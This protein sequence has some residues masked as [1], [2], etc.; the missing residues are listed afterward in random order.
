MRRRDFLRSLGAAS[1]SA[2]LAVAAVTR[3]GA[4]DEKSP[5][6]DAVRADFF[7]EQWR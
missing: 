6:E 3:V 5:A 2:G 1:C 7:D 4:G